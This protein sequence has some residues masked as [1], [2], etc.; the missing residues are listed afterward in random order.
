MTPK[1][2]GLLSDL[3]S[4]FSE[5][6]VLWQVVVLILC[7]LA[8]WGLARLLWARIV[9]RRTQGGATELDVEGFGRVLAPL[10]IC[11]LIMLA[12]PIFSH[13]HRA[14]L[15]RVAVPLSMSFA[16]IRLGFYIVNRAF[17]RRSKAG[18]FLVFEK[19]FATLV[20]IGVAL[21]ITGLWP[22]IIGYLEGTMLPIGSRKTSLLAVIQAG[23][24]V[25][26]TLVIA[27][28]ASTLLEERLM[29]MAGMHSSLRVVFSRLGRAALILV[30]VLLSLSL[31]GIDLTVLSVFGGALGVGIGLGLQKLVS[32][33][34]SGFVILLERSLSIGDTV[35]VDKYLG[36]ITQINT[37]YTII[38]GGDG[39]ETVVPND[40]LITA[41]VQNYSPMVLSHRIAIR[42]TVSYKSD[43]ER[44]LELL[45]TA[46]ASVARVAKDPA[47]QA[48]LLELAADG[49]LLELGFWINDPD[50]GRANVQSDVNR[51][52]WKTL[53]DNQ[54]ELPYPQ[55]EIRLIQPSTGT[56]SGVSATLE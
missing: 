3:W 19:A 24:S 29:R 17:S 12:V 9:A 13:W 27:L 25:V 15:L 20:W 10:L 50:N 8:G 42:L 46:A 5:P 49:F 33:H 7:M 41:P 39:I 47:P 36:K 23:V 14:N 6:G 51:V 54:V 40:L 43:I 30:A 31:V 22:D 55:R 11:G 52:V 18:G 34:V 32:S 16:L 56:G 1:L 37:R 4:D 35:M 21:Y 53:Q 45:Q 48:F 44:V 28:W 2:S 38:R 26:I